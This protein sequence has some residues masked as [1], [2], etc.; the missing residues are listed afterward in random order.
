VDARVRRER[1]RI[2]DLWLS[3]ADL[4]E[5]PFNCSEKQNVLGALQEA[6]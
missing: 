4:I 3:S 1:L 5:N 6:V 2:E